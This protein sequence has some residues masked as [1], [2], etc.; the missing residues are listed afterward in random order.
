MPKSS[1]FPGCLLVLQVVF[2]QYQRNCQIGSNAEE[3]INL[4]WIYIPLGAIAL[5]S[6]VEPQLVASS[7]VGGEVGLKLSGTT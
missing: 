7:I 6:H 4:L 2:E 3:L 1:S 5:Y